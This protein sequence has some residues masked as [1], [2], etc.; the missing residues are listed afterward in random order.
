MR[1]HPCRHELEN[2]TELCCVPLRIRSEFFSLH[3]K[4]R[5]DLP[6]RLY[7]QYILTIRIFLSFVRSVYS[8]QF[9]NRRLFNKNRTRTYTFFTRN[10]KR[11][12][13]FLEAAIRS[14]LEILI[15]FAWLSK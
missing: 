13:Y 10:I 12:K 6:D 9:F 3:W 14:V 5:G 15:N 8:F 2:K 7:H 11:K 4:I 1:E